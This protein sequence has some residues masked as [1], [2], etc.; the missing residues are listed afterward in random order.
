MYIGITYDLRS[1]YLAMG[2]ADEE[3]AEFDRDDTIRAIEAALHELE[4]RTD[5]IGNARQLTE[6]LVSGDR[7]DLVFNIAEG[8]T[9]ISREA[10]VPALLDLYEIPYTFSDALVMTLTMHKGMAKKVIAHSGC[11]T[12]AFA[13]INAAWETSDIRFGPPYFV[14]PVAEG[15]SKGITADSI[16]RDRKMLPDACEKLIC[17]FR[18]PVLV[19]RF[20]PGREFTVGI[21]GTGLSAAVLG[22]LEV[23]L[24]RNAEAD[25][26][27]YTNK[28]NCEELVEYRLVRPEDAPVVRETESLAL[29]IWRSL[30]CRDAGRVDFRC[31]EQGHPRFLE[32]NPLSGLHPAHSDLPI[33]CSRL[34]LPYIELIRRILA[35]AAERIRPLSR[36][37]DKV[38][39]CA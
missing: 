14:K 25:V 4:H 6:R 18:Q 27:S 35:S 15:T 9:G 24:L 19:E 38:R 31:D 22:T 39:Q 3:T 10:Q 12:P 16:V 11:P 17:K 32:A 36:N 13:V 34:G 5:R 20:M 33:L 1:E 2:Y 30:G 23:I 29:D 8:L 7:C 21:L 37:A 28:E 26:Y